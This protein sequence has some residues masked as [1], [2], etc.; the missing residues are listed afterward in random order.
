M[1][2]DNFVKLCAQ[3][4]VSCKRAVTDIGLSNSISTK[5][6]NGAIPNGATLQKLADYFGVS[7]ESLLSDESVSEK[8]ELP[9]TNEELDKALEGVNFALY[10]EAKD[11]TVKEKQDVLKFIQFLKSKRGE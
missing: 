7:V 11:L 9:A 8:N 4:G 5:W 2:Y 3:K 6:K 1:F 10:G